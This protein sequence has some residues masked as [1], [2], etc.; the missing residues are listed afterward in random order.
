MGHPTAIDIKLLAFKVL[1]RK[2][3][4]PHLAPK[5]ANNGTAHR[6]SSDISSPSSDCL[7]K[8]GP[9]S[10]RPLQIG[11]GQ[12]HTILF[13]LIGKRVSTPLGPGRLET[14]YAKRC[15]VVLDSDPG[16]IFVFTPAQI[17][18]PI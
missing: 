4:V 9:R 15:E 5:G 1:E 2:H 3:A 10:K 18:V 16:K 14:V 17:G 12:S 7:W 8:R 11:V 13:P 6:T